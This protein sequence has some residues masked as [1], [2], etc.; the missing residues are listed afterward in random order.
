MRYNSISAWYGLS[1]TWDRRESNVLLRDEISSCSRVSQSSPRN[2][3]AHFS[4]ILDEVPVGEINCESRLTLTWLDAVTRKKCTVSRFDNNSVNTFCIEIVIG[5]HLSAWI[6][7]GLLDWYCVWMTDAGLW[8][9][10]VMYSYSATATSV[11]TF[12]QTP[13]TRARRN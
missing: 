8:S 4:R 3:T 1:V 13:C 10:A 12:T 11:L 5:T 2:R 6:C 9:R 7:S